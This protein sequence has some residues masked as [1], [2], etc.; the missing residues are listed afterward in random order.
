MNASKTTA[1]PD[2]AMA[3]ERTV[4][5][6]NGETAPI[7]LMDNERHSGDPW[8]LYT[9]LREEAPVYKDA[10]GIWWVS[11][12]DDI[13]EISM[14]PDTWTS[15]EGNRPQIPP[16]H[17]FIHLDGPKHRERRNLIQRYFVPSAIRRLEQ[18]IR[19]VVT[20]LI[21]QVCEKGHCEYVDEVAAPLPNQL[22][23]EMTGIP[24]EHHADVRRMLDVF[25]KGGEGAEFVTEEVNE[26]FF[27]FGL[28]HLN[29]VAERMEQPRD[30]FLSLWLGAEVQGKPMSED[31]MLFEHVMLIVGGS[32]TTRNAVSGGLYMLSE[33][34]PEQRQLLL[35]GKADFEN[36]AEE[37]IRWTTPFVSMSRVCAKDVV[38]RGHAMKEGECVVLL[39]PPANRDPRKFD[40]PDTFDITRTFDNRVLSFGIGRH[41]CVGA[42]LARMETKV[43]LEEMC[44]RLPD[45]RLDGEA[46]WARSNFIRGM[47]SFPMSFTPTAK[48]AAR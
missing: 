36:A 18:H 9:W 41:V 14:N 3:P 6:P 8:P 44:K 2:D 34:H 20:E 29:L 39:Y 23:C 38:F 30:D 46:V 25:T 7:D 5:G 33:K 1:A 24:A 26:A 17:S 31:E 13:V 27:D 19:D 37:I 45:W 10:N 42:H 16:D 35:E 11:R 47:K 4:W 40:R 32:E 43:V 28:L 48:V 21:D 12:Y 22:I 15:S